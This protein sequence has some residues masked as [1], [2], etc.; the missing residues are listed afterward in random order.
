M[1]RSFLCTSKHSTEI[2]CIYTSVWGVSMLSVRAAWS[3]PGRV[4]WTNTSD[5]CT[6]TPITSPSPTGVSATVSVETKTGATGV[7]GHHKESADVSWTTKYDTYLK[8]WKIY[9]LKVCIETVKVF[10]WTYEI[11]ALDYF[12][13]LPHICSSHSPEG[14]VMEH[15]SNT[16]EQAAHEGLGFFCNRPV[17]R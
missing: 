12:L 10:Y 3:G 9:S 7:N 16:W 17:K 15:M 14:C 2:F 11:R 13:Y 1:F 4:F 6:N 8:Y 5:R